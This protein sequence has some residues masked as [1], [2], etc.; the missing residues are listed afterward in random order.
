MTRAIDAAKLDEKL[1]QIKSELISQHVIIIEGMDIMIRN[2]YGMIIEF[3]FTEVYEWL[4][5]INDY[6]AYCGG[7]CKRCLSR[8]C[9]KEG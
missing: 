3:D 7:D 4:H 6:S 2:K 8:M 1:R 5:D 9:E